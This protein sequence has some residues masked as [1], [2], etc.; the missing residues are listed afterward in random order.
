MGKINKIAIVGNNDQPEIFTDARGKSFVIGPSEKIRKAFAGVTAEELTE[1][2][3]KFTE[4]FPSF[5][6]FNF[7]TNF[8][9]EPKSIGKYKEITEQ[10]KKKSS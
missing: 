7:N 2:S 3:K 8:G 6:D 9:R 5:K 1:A 4:A 10:I